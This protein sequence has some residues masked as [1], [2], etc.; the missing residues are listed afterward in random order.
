[1]DQYRIVKERDNV[2]SILDAGGCSF[3]VVIGSERAAVIDTGITLNGEI[4]PIIAQ[5]TDKPLCLVITHAH[6]DHMHHVNEFETVYMSH[7]ELKIDKDILH[8]ITGGMESYLKD[9]ID[10]TTDSEINLGESVLS[11]CKVPGHTPG[12]VVILDEKN[13]MLFTGDAIGSGCGVFLQIVGTTTLEEYYQSLLTLM[14]W[15][16]SRAKRFS[17]CISIF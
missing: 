12:S 1:M 2:Y 16:Y 15:L 11:V 10:I 5:L 6:L 7:D 4:R 17:F 13:N 9:T 3:Y 14:R 8:Q